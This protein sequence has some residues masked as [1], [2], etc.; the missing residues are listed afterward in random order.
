VSCALPDK[1]SMFSMTAW[2]KLAG[3]PPDGNVY[4][5][6]QTLDR[7]GVEKSKFPVAEVRG[8]SGDSYLSMSNVGTVPNETNLRLLVAATVPCTVMQAWWRV[9]HW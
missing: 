8:T 1:A 9:L 4:V 5:R 2:L 3:L 6:V 7:G